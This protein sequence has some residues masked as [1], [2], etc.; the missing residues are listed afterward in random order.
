[1][2]QQLG[3]HGG[4]FFRQP[5][6]T[7]A[8]EGDKRHFAD[9]LGGRRQVGALHEAHQVAGQ[10][11]VHDVAAA[12]GHVAAEADGAAD[13]AINLVGRIVLVEDGFVAGK[14]QTRAIF[15]NPQQVI[16]QGYWSGYFALSAWR[17]EALVGSSRNRRAARDAKCDRH[18][19]PP[20]GASTSGVRLSL[21]INA[22]AANQ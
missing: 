22:F 1:M 11:E 2:T 16:G 4:I 19:D 17:E 9:G 14:M 12:I 6:K 21:S 7:D 3:A 10:K 5:V 13:D 15:L 18:D 20:D 8:G